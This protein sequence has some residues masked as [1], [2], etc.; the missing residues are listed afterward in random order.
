MRWKQG[1][2]F[3]AGGFVVGL[4]LFGMAL[5]YMETGSMEFFGHSPCGNYLR[6]VALVCDGYWINRWYYRV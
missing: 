5:I 4:P 1:E 3:G 2:V 6:Y